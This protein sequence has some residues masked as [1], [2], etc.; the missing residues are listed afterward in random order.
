MRG[1]AS[2]GKRW[3]I[4]VRDPKTGVVRRVLFAHDLAVATSGRAEIV[5]PPVRASGR[6]PCRPSPCSAPTWEWRTPTPPPCTRWDRC[7]PGAS[8]SSWAR[9]RTRA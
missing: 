7:S 9:A 5:N 1:S 4:G 6:R 2:P 3:R 8:G